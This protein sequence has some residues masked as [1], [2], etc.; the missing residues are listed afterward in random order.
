MKL[1]I[2]LFA[3]ALFADDAVKPKATVEQ[4]QA[5]ITWLEQK[6]SMTEAKSR[7]CFDLYNADSGLNTLAKQEPK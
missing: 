3:T 7:A 5:R 6:L 2:L 4:L 1:T